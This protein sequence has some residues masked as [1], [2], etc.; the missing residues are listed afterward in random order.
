V[1][2]RLA[3][4]TLVHRTRV[5]IVH[6]RFGVVVLILAAAGALLALLSIW[7]T[8]L[9]PPVRVYLRLLLVAVGLQVAVGLVLV[10]TGNRPQFLHWIYGAATLAAMPVAMLGG[11]NRGHR[12]EHLWLI[13]GAVATALLA[14]RA[15][16]TG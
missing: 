5:L 1:R 7:Q 14:F 16:S 12:E 15:V 9:L 13:G 8:R 3:A 11:N 10:I 2:R 6:D 4:R